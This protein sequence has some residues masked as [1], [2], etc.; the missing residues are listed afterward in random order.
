VAL[1]PRVDGADASLKRVHPSPHERD[2]GAGRGRPTITCR[3]GFVEVVGGLEVADS[4]LPT[5]RPLGWQE[6][7]ARDCVLWPSSRSTPDH[8][9]RGGTICMTTVRIVQTPELDPVRSETRLRR[10]P[11][12]G[13]HDVGHGDFKQRRLHGRAG[14]P[15]RNILTVCPNLECPRGPLPRLPT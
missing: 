7:M 1:L 14:V 6:S 11:R 4:A 5:W 15:P 8:R 2:I 10:T 12:H 13:P 3:A 9:R